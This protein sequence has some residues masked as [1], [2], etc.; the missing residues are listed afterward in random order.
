[1]IAK[2]IFIDTL[3]LFVFICF[4]ALTFEMIFGMT[5]PYLQTTYQNGITMRYFDFAMYFKTL[6][7][8]FT[9]FGQELS[10]QM[11]DKHWVD[12]GADFLYVWTNNMA[13]ILNYIIM[14]INILL[15]P[16]RLI[17]WLIKQ[18]LIILGQIPEAITINNQTYNPQWYMEVL[19]WISQKFA[20]PYIP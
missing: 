14:F 7:N 2:K 6:S 12:S 20:I 13:V 4:F 17:G 8:S 18:A 5:T 16:V 1:M 15:W 10:I 19:N 11:P 9:N 3:G